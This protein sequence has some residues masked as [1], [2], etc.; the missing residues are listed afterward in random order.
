MRGKYRKNVLTKGV[1]KRKDKELLGNKLVRIGEVIL[2]NNDAKN[3]GIAEATVRLFKEVSVQ[4][5]KPK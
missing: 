4:K 3:T 1:K 5:N 2:Y